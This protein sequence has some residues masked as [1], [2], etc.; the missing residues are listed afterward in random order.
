METEQEQVLNLLR[1]AGE[2]P[3]NLIGGIE[4]RDLRHKF[5]DKSFDHQQFIKGLSKED[6]DKLLDL[7]KE[8]LYP[9]P[10]PPSETKQEVM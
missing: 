5:L 10:V 3:S 9:D 6:M 7:Q 1:E 8:E 4:W 2:I